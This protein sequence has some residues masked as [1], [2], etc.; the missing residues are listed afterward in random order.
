MEGSL[1]PIPVAHG[2]G[3]ADFSNTGNLEACKTQN[4][5][6]L[7]Y[8]NGQAQ[9]ASTYPHN[10]NGSPEGLTAFTTP[11]GRATILM[12]HPERCFRSVQMSY[13]APGTFE[14][15]EGPWMRMFEN[16]FQSMN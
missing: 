8:I 4:L 9:P 10:P 15:E 6:A 5:T 14:N 1:L 11:D 3:R 7:R 12:P 13:R 16:A 2:E